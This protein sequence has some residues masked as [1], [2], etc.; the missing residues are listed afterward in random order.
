MND[1]PPDRSLRTPRETAEHFVLHWLSYSEPQWWTPAWRT[2]CR[3]RFDELMQSVMH[4]D[5]ELVR[6]LWIS[7]RDHI[8]RRWKRLCPGHRPMLWYLFDSPLHA[9]PAIDEAGELLLP[10]GDTPPEYLLRHH[11]MDTREQR[12]YFKLFGD[13]HHATR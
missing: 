11:L 12:R 4:G 3:E 1:G 7:N 9:L 10:H 13:R 6:P 5:G 8:V 2:A